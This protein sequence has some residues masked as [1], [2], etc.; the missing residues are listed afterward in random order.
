[1]I[2]KIGVVSGAIWNL[3][4]K[5]GKLSLSTLFS[6]IVQDTAEDKDVVC[7]GVGWLAREGH[8]VLERK[9]SDYIACLRK[10]PSK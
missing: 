2:I 3:L 6:K 8:I 7:M 5:E 10:P 9:D 1:M 4:E